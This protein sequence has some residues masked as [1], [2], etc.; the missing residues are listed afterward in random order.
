MPVLRVSQPTTTRGVTK[1]PS[2]ATWRVLLESWADGQVWRTDK[3][4]EFADRDIAEHLAKLV[5]EFD[6]FAGQ[7]G[8]VVMEC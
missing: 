1:P 3:L 2:F 5:T 8:V 4:A 6:G 7:I